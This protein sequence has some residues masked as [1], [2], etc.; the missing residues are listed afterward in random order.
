MF[1]F[2]LLKVTCLQGLLLGFPEELVLKS[3]NDI[4]VT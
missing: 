1:Y 4:S 3:L 2:F